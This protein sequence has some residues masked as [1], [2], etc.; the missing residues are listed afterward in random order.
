MTEIPKNPD[1]IMLAKLKRQEEPPGQVQ[2]VLS[3]PVRCPNRN[4]PC[5]IQAGGS[6]YD[7]AVRGTG[8]F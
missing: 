3:E 6:A 4:R 5:V 7:D 1:K 2:E 8:L